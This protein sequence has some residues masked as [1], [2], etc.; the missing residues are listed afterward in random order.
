MGEK[1]RINRYLA[2]AGIGSRR[3]C[4]KLIIDGRV[5]VNGKLVTELSTRID[6]AEDDVWV[7]GRP[8]VPA[9]KKLVLVLNKPSGVL[10]TVEDRYRRK[11]VIDIAREKGYLERLFPVGR[12]DMDTTGLILITNDGELAY[13]LTH[14]KFKVEKTY[15]V[16]VEGHISEQTINRIKAGLNLKE[17]RTLPCRI[18]LLNYTSDHSELEVTIKEGKKRQIKRMFSA[19]GHKVL[20]LHRKAIADLTF[21]DVDIGEIRELKEDELKRLR[22][23]VGLA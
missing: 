3:K 16:V 4:E 23:L 12:L 11:T 19:F 20:R 22:E 18:K 15:H 13:R 9:G 2:M 8:V 5:S 10:S 21:E 1:I 7:D 14:P 6:L 17:L